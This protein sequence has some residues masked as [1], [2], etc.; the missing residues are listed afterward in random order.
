M[1]LFFAGCAPA[2]KEEKNGKE[3]SDSVSVLPE[4]DSFT[5]PFTGNDERNIDYSQVFSNERFKEVKVTRKGKHTFLVTGKAQIFEA[6]F[7][8]VVEDG[9]NEL[10]KG[11]ARTE[12]GA[13][14]WGDF[15]F[16][17]SAGKQDPNTTLMLILFEESARDGSRQY[18][19]PVPLY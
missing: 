14:S 5:G 1:I 6:V 10:L 16:E 4:N 15:S 11:H 7:G 3:V 18:E 19:L 2:N 17:I 13:P 9:H 8:W 12:A